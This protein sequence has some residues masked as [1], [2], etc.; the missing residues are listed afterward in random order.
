MKNNAPKGIAVIISNG[1]EFNHVKKF[2]TPEVLY[3]DWHK[4]MKLF[5]TAVVLKANESSKYSSG[6]TGLAEG[7]KEEGFKLVPFSE[8]LVQYLIN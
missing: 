8:N 5:E 1:R 2:L 7:Y 6:S 3:L 4:N